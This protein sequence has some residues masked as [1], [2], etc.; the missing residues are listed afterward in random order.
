[1]EGVGL[2]A[3]LLLQ[4]SS[5]LPTTILTKNGEGLLEEKE[6]VKIGRAHV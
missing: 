3:I 6:V 5:Q 1:M 4:V 2:V